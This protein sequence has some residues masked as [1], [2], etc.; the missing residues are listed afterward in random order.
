MTWV[1]GCPCSSR[2]GGPLPAWRRVMTASGVSIKRGVK[3]SNMLPL[4]YIFLIRASAGTLPRAPLA[5]VDMDDAVPIDLEASHL[6]VIAQIGHHP[7]HACADPEIDG[8]AGQMKGVAGAAS[9]PV[10]AAVAMR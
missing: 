3:L 2:T 5:I 10:A 4:S 9:T 7:A 8:A 1:C 6:R